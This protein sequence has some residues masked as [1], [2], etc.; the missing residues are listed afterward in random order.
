MGA[1][2]DKKDEAAVLEVIVQLK[3]TEKKTW[4]QI[5]EV[6]AEKNF[7]D[8]HGK[9]ISASAA[10][11]RYRRSKG[12]SKA[13]KKKGDQTEVTPSYQ[14]EHEER[15]APIDLDDLALRATE[16]VMKQTTD[17]MKVVITEVIDERFAAMTPPSPVP[18]DEEKLVQKVTETIMNTTVESLKVFIQESIAEKMAAITPLSSPSP[19]QAP[20]SDDF[21][22]EPRV[23]SGAGKGRRETR[24]YARI[25]L[26]IDQNLWDL[27]QRDM[28]RMKV[29]AGRMI[30]ILLWRAYGKPRL[31]FEEPELQEVE[32]GKTN[33]PANGFS[34]KLQEDD[35]EKSRDG[36]GLD[37]EN[38]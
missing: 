18:V 19:V 7:T 24:K 37:A 23:I 26:T 29:S 11:A 22:P 4:K 36:E 28:E 3:E 32:S 9:P 31:S 10:E 27:V 14:Y 34:D 8:S 17:S 38:D 6:L 2:E 30:D 20:I 16:I 13:S 12:I 21:P 15:P 1:M 5:S 33:E 25:S 35:H